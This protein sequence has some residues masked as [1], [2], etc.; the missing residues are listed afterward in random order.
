MARIAGLIATLGLAGAGVAGGQEIPTADGVVGHWLGTLSIPG[1]ELRIVFHVERSDAGALSGTL[2]SPDQGA[3]GL[4]LSSV[5]QQ[6]GSVVFAIASLGGRYAGR[7]SE[8]GEAIEGEWSQGG[9]TF[10]LN[11]RRTDTVALAPVRPQEPHAPLPYEAVDVEFENPN[12]AIRLAGTLTIPAG[13]GPH[14]AVALITGSGPQ[15]RDETV[16]G[17]RPFLVLA[18]HLTRRGIEVLRYDDRGIGGSTG[19]FGTATTEDFAGDALAAVSFLRSRP[20]VDPARIG[21]LGHSEGAIVAP[22]VAHRSGDVAFV[23]LLAG[24]GVNG[25]DLLIMQAKAINRASGLDETAV[26][27]RSELQIRLLD[28]AAS[29]G[30]DSAVSEQARAI[31]AAEGVTGQAAEGQVRALVSPWMKY[32]LI[33]DPLPALRELD[34]PVLALSG[35]KDTQVPPV[36]NLGAVEQALREGGNADVTTE[37]MPGLNHL[38]QT[39]ETGSPAEYGS[40][41]QT[42]SPAALDVIADWIASRAG[43]E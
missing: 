20:E 41:E 2:D 32:F 31:L 10:P 11:L 26:E 19:N 14:P 25:R 34:V 43:L 40:I 30:S 39:A 24:T 12:A 9:G 22:I 1:M 42:M 7:L 37:V 33:Y 21:L 4:R 6:S 16:F 27:R 23:V 18:D 29:A 28:V 36:E 3:Y 5:E 17:H 8:G 13:T 38:F 35:E 15:D